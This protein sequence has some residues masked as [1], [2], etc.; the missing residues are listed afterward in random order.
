MGVTL[1]EWKDFLEY[2]WHLIYTKIV[3]RKLICKRSLSM[4]SEFESFIKVTAIL[5]KH[6][7]SNHWGSLTRYIQASSV[8]IRKRKQ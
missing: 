8:A 1:T 2:K 6:L 7:N 3:Y 4:L 5:L